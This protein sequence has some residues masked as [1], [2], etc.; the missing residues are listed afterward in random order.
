MEELIINENEE[1]RTIALM[2]NTKLVELY[3]EEKGKRPLDGNIYCGIVR[4]ILP[5]MQSAF[6]DIGERKNAFLHIKDIIPKV[7]DE[8]GN[9]CEKMGK[10][11]I[12]DYIKP[13]MPILVQVKKEEEHQKGAKISININLPGRYVIIL[14]NTNFVTVSQKINDKVEVER[15]K[16]I[17]S[18]I[19]ERDKITNFGII[20]R[21]CAEG[22]SE[23]ELENDLSKLLILWSK[24]IEQY[25]EC[26][27][28]GAPIK[29]YEAANT[30][31]KLIIGTAKNNEYKIKVNNEK[32]LQEVNEILRGLNIEN[33]KL[34]KV[35]SGLLDLY[36]LQD[37]IENSKERKI[38]LKSGG[39]IT[40][41]RT[42]ALTAIDVNSGKFIGK[43]TNT[44][45]DTI[46]DVNKE[47]TIEIA[48]QLRL[49][50]ISGIIV[51]DYID[52][53][54]QKER[55]GIIK[56]LEGELKKD[57]SKTQVMGFTKLDLLEMTRK[58]I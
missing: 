28:I 6:V 42:E 44:K 53:E 35:E 26:K 32:L 31:Q 17:I 33:V 40:I 24:I 23:E 10:Y 43:K 45:D 2:Q 46:F 38:W 11:N 47:A 19:L 51:I 18:N 36:D 25:E 56:L 27:N 34:E 49:K 54:K 57:R 4:N 20:I 5:G 15:L 3:E 58:K 14:P 7:N 13:K 9:K 22:A 39:F 48:K 12:N 16:K 55:D 8:T 1:K 50:N 30:T 52:M 41:D 37:Q 21:T 29:I